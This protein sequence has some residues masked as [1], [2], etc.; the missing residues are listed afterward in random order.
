ML[1]VALPCTVSGGEGCAD[2]Q[3]CMEP[4]LRR[5]MKFG[6]G[7]R[8]TTLVRGAAVRN[9]V[10]LVSAFMAQACLP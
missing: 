10:P 1:A 9:P 5:F 8:A 7:F 3:R 6:Y 4:F 2:M